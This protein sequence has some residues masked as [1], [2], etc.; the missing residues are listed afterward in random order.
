M[1]PFI[2]VGVFVIAAV[3]FVA[4]LPE[5]TGAAGNGGG[6]VIHTLFHPGA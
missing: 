3:A 5:Y 1:R 6:T 4:I 2:V